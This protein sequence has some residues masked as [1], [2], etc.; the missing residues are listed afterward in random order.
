VEGRGLEL[1]RERDLSALLSDTV[2]VMRDHPGPLL[3]LAAAIVVPVELIVSGIGLERLTADYRPHPGRAEQLIPTILG[4]FVIAPLIGAAVIQLL[5]E[6]STGQRPGTARCLQA[7]LDAFAP[8]FLAV[9]IMAAGVAI[10]LAALLLPGIYLLVR[11]FFVTQTVVIEDKRGFDALGRSGDLVRD[12]WWR[13][14]GIVIVSQ[15]VAAVPAILIS[16]PMEALAKSADRE[17]FGLAGD[18]LASVV[19]APFVAILTTLLF[20]DLR[21]RRELLRA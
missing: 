18:I 7:G 1:A 16:L 15:L 17:V 11:W 21:A 3:L 4:F 13:V 19:T 2:G 20:Y 12:S 10:G 6:V 5:R 14:F 9:V 8:L